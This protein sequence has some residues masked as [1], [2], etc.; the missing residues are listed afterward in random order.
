MKILA[1]NADAAISIMDKSNGSVLLSW[2]LLSDEPKVKQLE[3]IFLGPHLLLHC[4]TSKKWL[5]YYF[6]KS[7]L[8]IAGLY[9]FSYCEYIGLEHVPVMAGTKPFGSLKV[10]ACFFFFNV[11]LIGKCHLCTCISQR[12]FTEL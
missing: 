12:K 6:K 8:Y 11:R 2:C 10:Q 3:V 1:P 7:D 4:H 5:V 9:V